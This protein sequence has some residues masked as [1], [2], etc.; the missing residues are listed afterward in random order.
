MEWSYAVTAVPQRCSDL[1][2][3]TLQQL[4]TAGFSDPVVM[5]DGELPGCSTLAR[6][7]RVATHPKL[8]H[9]RNWALALNY[10]YFQ[11]PQA[12]RF[13]IFEDDLL[14][15]HNLR[16][17][18]EQCPYP[19]LGYW[20][21]LTHNQNMMK[22]GPQPGWYLS[23]QRGWG[24]VGLVFDQVTVQALLGHPKWRERVAF[25]RDS[26]DGLVITLLKKLG[27]REWIHSPSLLQHVGVKSTFTNHKY[28]RVLGWRENYDPLTR[29][30]TV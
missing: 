29:K 10:I 23:N 22:A 3:Q 24:A 28:G 1:L 27:Y 25:G 19:E 21:L 17:Y 6:D 18:L 26:A 8:G 11:N 14:C 20:N 2:P 15:C 5:L 13:A 9:I 30:E 16:V 4:A 12:E 7:Q